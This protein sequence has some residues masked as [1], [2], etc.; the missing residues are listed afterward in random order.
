M[1]PVLKCGALN[2]VNQGNSSSC[3]FL[4]QHCDVGTAHNKWKNSLSHAPTQRGGGVLCLLSKD[5]LVCTEL[6]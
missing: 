6:C 5:M 1:N 2:F 4:T 3:V